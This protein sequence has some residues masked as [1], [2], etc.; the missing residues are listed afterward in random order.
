[1]IAKLNKKLL[2]ILA[3]VLCLTFVFVGCGEEEPEEHTHTYDT[4]KWVSD[5]TNHWHAST[6]GHENI[7]VAKH[8]DG[9]D[10]DELCDACG[11]DMHE[12][13]F[14]AEWNKDATNHWHDVTCGHEVEVEKIAHADENGDF[15]CDACEYVLHEHTFGTEWEKDATHHWHEA[16]C[17]HDIKGDYAEHADGEDADELCDACGTDL[18][19]HS[20]AEEWSK[21]ATNHWHA[22]LCGHDNIDTAAHADGDDTDELCDVCGYDLHKHAFNT[23]A[24]E[25]DVDGHWNP[26]TCGHDVK[27]NY[28][29]HAD[30]DD[31]DTLCDVC[32][33]E[34]HVHTFNTEEWVTD[35]DGHWHASTC[36]H[37]DLKADYAEHADGDDEDKLCDACGS[38]IHEHTYNSFFNANSTHHWY[39]SNCVHTGL[40]KDYAEHADGDDEDELC[41]V[42][43]WDLHEH[44]FADELSY[45]EAGHWYAS[46]CGHDDT[47]TKDAHTL[48][49]EYKCAC[50]F[51]HEHTFATEWSSDET[52][53]W[54]AATC[55]HA[56]E[57]YVEHTM[58]AFEICSAC[59]YSEHES[60]AEVGVNAGV[61]NADQILQGTVTNDPDTDPT[62]NI[63]EIRDGYIYIKTAFNT[64]YYYSEMADGSTFGIQVSWGEVYRDEYNSGG[65]LD[66]YKFSGSAFGGYDSKF[67]GVADLMATLYEMA[68]VDNLNQDFAESYADGV[69]SFSFGYYVDRDGLNLINVSFTL[70]EETGVFETIDVVNEFYG[71]YNDNWELQLVQ[72]TEATDDTPATWG[73]PEGVEPTIYKVSIVLST[74]EPE[75]YNVE[76]PYSAEKMIPTDFGLSTEEGG[77]AAEIFEIE[78]GMGAN[79]YFVDILPEGAYATFATV[80]VTGDDALNLYNYGSYVEVKVYDTA[81]VGAE[82]SFTVTVN[83]VAKTY[84]VKVVECV[85]TAIVAGTVASQWG[86]NYVNEVESVEITEG[87]NVILG[88]HL[89]KPAGNVVVTI[90]PDGSYNA[91]DFVVNTGYS[92]IYQDAGFYAT[93]YAYN[94]KNLAAGEYTVTFTC[95]GNAELTKSITVTVNEKPPLPEGAVVIENVKTSFDYGFNDYYVIEA[96]KTGTYTIY[97]PEGLGFW[98]EKDYNSNNYSGMIDPMANVSGTTVLVELEAGE[99]YGFYIGAQ[100]VAEWEVYYT[101]EVP[102]IDVETTDTFAWFVDEYTFVAE[103][104]GTYTFTIPAGLGF[105]S[106]NAQEPEIDF[107]LRP[108]GGVVVV[109][110]EASEEYSFCVAAATKATWEIV[111][112]VEVAAEEDDETIKD[113]NGL[114]GEYTFN[115]T[116]EFVLT[117]TPESA[118]ATN[119][120]LQVVENINWSD[121][122]YNYTIVDGA[123]VFS[124][125]GEETNDVIVTLL[126]GNQWGFQMAAFPAMQPQVFA[127]YVAPSENEG[128]E[129]KDANGLGGEYTFNF[130]LDWVLVFTPDSAGATTGT[131]SVKDSDNV[132]TTY[133][134]EIVNGEYVFDE[135]DVSVYIDVDAWMFKR[136]DMAIA[137]PFAPYEA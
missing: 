73:A 10:A 79:L 65:D 120:T 87:K 81:E 40:K 16:T 128:E 38:E 60:N 95:E 49:A 88:A 137:K 29:E 127:E 24:W 48:D 96:D 116:G 15:K 105:F 76:N 103:V 14:A 106:A 136:G 104:A 59:G 66:G 97:L 11:Y 61:E 13:T 6:C 45:D 71:Y 1:M 122:T 34:L 111:Y 133:N 63:F 93:L 51:K 18:H 37:T 124:L 94:L 82:L 50:G 123:Y 70:N 83:G 27:G 92:G 39:E 3:M 117:F 4:S 131:L 56:V 33:S 132:T 72:L 121:V 84:T 43:G 28:A 125:N 91:D 135:E 26:A 69:F 23:E 31:E 112:S 80:E 7:D 114:G 57:E 44:T 25:K 110:L 19:E 41:D 100:V 109:E 9:D 21:D 90:T 5:D 118:G 62:V 67:Y 58:N 126:P 68:S 75:N 86:S 119:G 134:Y 64:E 30:G 42:C 74:E 46:T 12:H 108:E 53:H 98:S 8:K 89:D 115:W 52:K 22:A 54:H 78:L 47:I 113:A 2:A 130:I 101:V 129:G 20:Y 32:G 77:E 35:I 36:V 99:T 102:H 17:D 85:P 55:G 107:Q